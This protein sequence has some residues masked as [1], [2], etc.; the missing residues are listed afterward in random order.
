MAEATNIWISGGA[1]SGKS[2]A[3]EALLGDAELM[4]KITAAG[5]LPVRV[6]L[7]G[8]DMQGFARVRTPDGN[9]LQAMDYTALRNILESVVSR[10][11][12][13]GRKQTPL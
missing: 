6:V 13:H 12:S 10:F 7:G 4:P 2:S 3:L 11:T 1:K 5:Q 8:A 9:V